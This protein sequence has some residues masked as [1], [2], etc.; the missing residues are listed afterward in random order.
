MKDTKLIQILKTFSR[1]EV[2][3]FEKFA[4]SPY[5]S[6]GRDLTPFYKIFKSFHPDFNSS[7]FTYEKIFRKL[8]P[9]EKYLKSKSENV[10]RML[11]SE[12]SKLAEEFIIVRDLRSNKFRSRICLME[13]FLN[14]NLN[15]F[16][17]KLHSDTKKNSDKL[18]EGYTGWHFVDLYH[19]NMLEVIFSIH[20][21][22]KAASNM[23]SQINMMNFF[24]LCAAN[25]INNSYNARVRYNLEN[26]DDLVEQF[27][28]NFDHKNF[29][30]YLDKKKGIAKQDKEIFELCFY[31]LLYTIHRKDKSIVEKIE[32]RFYKNKHL[33]RDNHKLSF[34]YLLKSYYNREKDFEKLNK[35]YSSLLED[36]VYVPLT[37]GEMPFIAYNDILY[38]LVAQ[39]KLTEAQ[40]FILK[41]TD[42]LRT[43]K[44]ESFRNYGIAQIEFK[45]RNFA[46]S[47]ECISKVEMLTFFFKYEIRNLY[48]KL[49]Y[50]LNYLEE[51]RSLLDTYKH[52]LKSNKYV[53]E[54]LRLQTKQFVDYYKILLDQKLSGSK[55]ELEKYKKCI[56]NEESLLYKDWLLEKIEEFS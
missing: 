38:N 20:N 9:D 13:F 49:Y 2:K 24:S 40:K 11:S 27:M 36:E 8:Y 14:N 37:G 30:S 46:K 26:K 3:E 6:R 5:F 22:G 1:E 39:N 17:L 10:L 29:I 15:A 50:E 12:L 54:D 35:L 47:L 31:G 41:Y 33:F 55:S 25:F 45:K 19:L 34:Y 18:S 43:D 4:A 52:F 28:R 7:N 48:L 53:S 21:N 51:A 56:A 16:F 42:Y 23:E 44:K 32:T